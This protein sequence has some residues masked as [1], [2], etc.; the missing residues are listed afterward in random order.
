MFRLRA[1]LNDGSTKRINDVSIDTSFSEL[2]DKISDLVSV[3][4]GYKIEI[5]AGHPPK[6]IMSKPGDKMSDIEIQKGDLLIVTLVEKTKEEEVVLVENNNENEENKN[7]NNDA[8]I[9]NI[10][11]P[12]LTINEFSNDDIQTPMITGS[13]GIICRRVVNADN[14]CLFNAIGYTL[15]NHSRDL[16]KELRIV[17]A[18]YILNHPV[19]YSDLILNQ[20]RESY[21]K[22]ILTDSAW[23]GGI[24]LSI[25]SKYFKTEIVVADTQSGRLDRYS[26]NKGYKQKILLIYDGIHYDPLALQLAEGLPEDC[27]VTIFSPNDDYPI[28]EALKLSEKARKK[29]LYTDISKFTLRCLVC[30]EGLVGHSEAQEHAMKTG[31]QNFAEYN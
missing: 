13:E 19:D 1:R 3:P 2:I 4:D 24:E 23:G 6:Q 27:D 21:I 16:S 15:F 12:K 30:Q 8:N 10:L 26:S 14:S 11:I 9:L 7:N 31:H 29:H 22:W 20:S 5:K 25:F 18:H 17:I 28:Q